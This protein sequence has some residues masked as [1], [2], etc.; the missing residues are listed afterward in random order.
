[1]EVQ[2]FLRADRGWGV[3]SGPGETAIS[4]MGEGFL[5]RSGAHIRA[6]G[7][8]GGQGVQTRR[9]VQHRMAKPKNPC[10]RLSLRLGNEVG[11]V[12]YA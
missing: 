3:V 8:E 4:G 5:I 12:V 9:M 11:G 1:M 7:W 2:R 6:G 10:L